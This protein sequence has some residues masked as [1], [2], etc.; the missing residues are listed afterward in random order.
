MVLGDGRPTLLKRQRASPCDAA[1]QASSWTPCAEVSRDPSS[2]SA[3]KS[4][5]ARLPP[6]ILRARRIQSRQVKPRLD[7][8]SS[9]L[10]FSGEAEKLPPPVHSLGVLP[11]NSP[12]RLVSVELTNFKAFEN[13]VLSFKDQLTCVVGPN[14]SGKSSIAEA[15]AFVLL[16]AAASAEEIVRLAPDESQ[17]MASVS[18]HFAV[19]HTRILMRRQLTLSGNR[20]HSRFWLGCDGPAVEVNSNEY[21][22]GIA[23]LRW[24]DLSLPQFGLLETRSAS[25][26]LQLLPAALRNAGSKRRGKPPSDLEG[27]V[28]QRLDE[29]YR[30]LTREPLDEAMT[31]WGEGGQL[32]LKRVGDDF[33]IFASERRGLRGSALDKLSD[34]DRD[35]CGLALLLTLPLLGRRPMFLVLDEPDARLDRRRAAALR[36]FLSFPGGPQCLLLSLNNHRAFDEA[37][38]LGK[39]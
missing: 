26:L 14:A 27:C 8:Q 10:S 5:D 30:E 15:I 16:R 21:A 2:C 36:R 35:V 12:A 4:A 38:R 23:H 6:Q 9:E 29:I 20:P 18:A 24:Q 11:S 17:D 33:T 22:A 34:G 37:L 7:G 3:A 32:T 1:P 31:Q 19:G 28:G 25:R 13:H 39:P